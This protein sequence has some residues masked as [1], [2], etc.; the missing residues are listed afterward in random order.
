MESSRWSQDITPMQKLTPPATRTFPIFILTSSWGGP[1]RR[2]N[3]NAGGG[4]QKK[5]RQFNPGKTRR[6]SCCRG[7]GRWR[8]LQPRRGAEIER[9]SQC[10]RLKGWAFLF[11]VI[12]NGECRSIAAREDGRSETV[13]HLQVLLPRI[14]ARVRALPLAISKRTP[15]SD[16]PPPSRGY[17]QFDVGIPT[18]A[19]SISIFGPALPLV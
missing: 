12:L 7:G 1:P 2:E 13:S 19:L 11:R 8:K 5:E 17:S 3:T 10:R 6:K 4:H 14:E 18:S 9:G 15:P 16:P